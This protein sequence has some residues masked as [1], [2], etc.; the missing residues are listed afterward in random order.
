MAV[1][2]NLDTLPLFH[3]PVLTIGSFDGLHAGHRTI[4]DSV[5][6]KARDIGG[7]SVL[8]TF[9][10][11]PRKVLFPDQSLQ[12]LTPLPVKIQLIEAAGIDHTVVVP[13]SPRFAAEE[14]EEYVTQFLVAHFKPQ[15]LVIGY[16]HRFGRARSGDINLLRKLGPLNGFEVEE[17]SAHLIDEAAVSSTKIRKALTTGHVEDAAAMLG[18]PYAWEGTVVKG[19]QLGRTLGYPTANLEANFS[20]QLLPSD[21]VYAVHA[22]VDGIKHGAMLSIGLRPTLGAG[23]ART[24][25]VNLFDFNS[26]LY[27]KSIMLHFIGRLRDE[28]K[29]A[30]LDELTEAIRNDEQMARTA[31]K[32][33]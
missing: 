32:M 5:V 24:V 2:Y 4:L 13:F 26:D 3:K 9:E 18:R 28:E 19:R 1:Y 14:P 8:L 7:E 25:E 12:L 11:H 33:Q 29:F 31:L 16:D 6:A 10:P 30:S 17:I 21:G 20:D 15:A 22:D 23:L 27:G